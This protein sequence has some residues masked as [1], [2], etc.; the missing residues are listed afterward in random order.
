MITFATPWYFA[1]SICLLLLAALWKFYNYKKVTYNYSSLNILGSVKQASVWPERLIKFLTLSSLALICIALAQPRK[2]DIK[3]KLPVEGIDI[4]LAI[5]ASGSMNDIEDPRYPYTRFSIAKNAALN[6]IKKRINDSIGL[7]FF[8]KISIAR[9][10]V[11][12]DKKLLEDI[13]NET[14]IG[15][16][17]SEGTVISRALLSSINRLKNSTAK[18]KIIILL[19]DG[20]PTIPY[21]VDV[22]IPIKLA[23]ELSIRIYTVGIGQMAKVQVGFFGQMAQIPIDWSFLEEISNRTGGQFFLAKKARDLDLI[24]DQI[25]QLEKSKINTPIFGKYFE[26][27]LPINWL[28]F[29]ILTARLFLNSFIWVMI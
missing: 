25:D 9:T 21:D 5:D 16:V 11:T 20:M 27:F 2:P 29:I 14:E 13:L 3:S 23:Q 7:V 26:Y 8:G 12:F 15:V 1:I 4:M 18:T 6:F 28:V 22:S 17:N 10:P 24:Y 19:S